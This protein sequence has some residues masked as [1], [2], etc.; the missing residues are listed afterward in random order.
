[1]PRT[2]N[3]MTALTRIA[4]AAVLAAG[5]A[6]CGPH[7]SSEAPEARE[8]SIAV[9]TAPAALGEVPEPI[10]AGGTV[11]AGATAVVT[12]R[13]VAPVLEVRVRAGDR[14]RAGQVLA[15]LDD[16]ALGAQARQATAS[17]AAAEQALISVRTEHA[18]AGADQKLADAWHARVAALHERRAATP[19][20]LD[21]AEARRSGAVARAAGAQARIEQATS[22]VAAARA[23][24]E[25]A[26]TTH[27]FAVIR[28]PFA[29]LVT[30]RLTDPGNLASPGVPLLRL[31]AEG[32]PRVEVR[33]DEARAGLVAPGDAVEVLFE[34]EGAAPVAGIVTEVARAVAADER[35]FT[36]KVSLP[37]DAAVRTGTFAR[38]RF[39]GPVRKALL[40]PA[41]AI[42][43]QGQVA[44]AFVVED[45]TARLRL[46]QTG[47]VLG[48]RVEVVAGLDPGEPVVV[49]PP[50]TLADGRRVTASAAASA[51]GEDR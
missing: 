11:A 6:A 43:R 23:A 18:A 30:E 22:Q 13:V 44:T 46:L 15:V 29:G 31:D 10:E 28:A 16:G 2:N 34:A 37:K 17:V 27:G 40:V 47:I 32:A 41:A 19:Q 25:A 4:A 51:A 20:E 21:E 39:R 45:R 48:E 1:M 49:N 26:G 38:V 3:R 5:A 42:R 35:A 24:A 50:P 12:S 33:V 7:E 8:P 14:V 36:V 9:T